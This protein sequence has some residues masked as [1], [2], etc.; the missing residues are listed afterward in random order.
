MK[1]LDPL[2]NKQVP[3]TPEERVRQWFI[4]VLASECGVPRGLMNS[5]VGFK[6]SDKQFR[7][8]ILIW[9]RDAKPLAVVE[10]KA[11]DVP[12]SSKVLDQ[13]ARYNMVL[14]IKWIFLTNGRS[15]SVLKKNNNQFV[16]V[17]TLPKYDEMLS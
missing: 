1:T 2:R 4:E 17:G 9:D 16:P 13:A 10:C 11:P 15:T 14:D 12:L 3:L 8:D 5:E 7:A 6:L